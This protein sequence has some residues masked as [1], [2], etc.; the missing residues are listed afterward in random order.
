MSNSLCSNFQ[1]ITMKLSNMS[2]LVI[3]RLQ[4]KKKIFDL[5]QVYDW[6]RVVRDDFIGESSVNLDE[7]EYNKTTSKV[8]SLSDP[9]KG[10]SPIEDLGQI[11]LDIQILPKRE[12]QENPKAGPAF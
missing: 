6:D 11:E 4:L 7:L 10:D 5:F 12:A 1:G 9:A 2:S 3:H 8:I